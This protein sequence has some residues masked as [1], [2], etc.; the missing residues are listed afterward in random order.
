M[1]ERELQVE[2]FIPGREFAV[3]GLVTRG[4]LQPLAIFDKPDPL[5]GPYFEETIYVTPS[6]ETAEVQQALI[7]TTAQAVRA[8]GLTHGRSTRNCATTRKARGFWKS[9]ARPIGGLC[10]RAVRLADGIPARRA[11]PAPRARAKMSSRRAQAHGA[12]GVMMIPIPKGGIYHSVEGVDRARRSLRNR[13]RHHHRDRRTAT[14]PAAGRMPA[15]WDLSSRGEKRPKAWK[16]RCAA[17]TR[18]WI[19]HRHHAR[20][21]QPFV[22]G[23]TK[24]GGKCRAFAEEVIVH[25]LRSETPAPARCQDSAGTRS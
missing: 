21:V 9:H 22:L 16:Q 18:N 15:I 1:G 11:D 5:E 6:R 10:A 8:L 14:R 23:G 7:E 12:S 17:R 20:N 19:P 2:A 3:E 13:R 24:S 25:L 4:E